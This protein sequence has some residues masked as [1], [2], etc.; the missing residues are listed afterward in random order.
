[1]LGQEEM[2]E[3][4]PPPEA[5]QVEIQ[6]EFFNVAEDFTWY[7]TIACTPNLASLSIQPPGWFATFAAMAGATV[8]SFFNVRNKANTELAYCNLDTRDQTAY[9]FQADSMSLAFFGS[10]FTPHQDA[11]GVTIRQYLPNAIWQAQLPFESSLTLRIQQDDKTKLNGMMMSP[12]YGPVGGGYGNLGASSAAAAVIGGGI[13]LSAQTQGT[14]GPWAK[15]KFH[16]RIDIPRRS[17]L[18]AELNF[19]QYGRYLL[20]NMTGPGFVPAWEPTWTTRSVD[21]PI[22]FG[23][24]C[25]IHGRRLVQQRGK[26]HA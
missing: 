13:L 18:A 6:G 5:E 2:M 12:G 24:Q 19:T 4:P 9:A 21:V 14:A 1:M 8:H 23:I 10:G 15:I 20:T 22:M 3:A 25:A 7:D 16:N 17:S 11:T 26:L